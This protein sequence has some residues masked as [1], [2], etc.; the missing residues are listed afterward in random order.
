MKPYLETSIR[1]STVSSDFLSIITVLVIET[2]IL[3]KTPF[4]AKL[5]YPVDTVD[6]IKLCSAL[7]L[8]FRKPFS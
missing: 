1:E 6:V 2:H 8:F 3:M 5:N 7:L 4:K